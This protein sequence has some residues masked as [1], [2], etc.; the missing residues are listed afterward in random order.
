M[1][2]SSIRWWLLVTLV[3]VWAPGRSAELTPTCAGLSGGPRQLAL[4]LLESEHP[5]DCCD[6][7]I[8]RCLEAEQVC[9]LTWRLAENICRRADQ[10]QDRARIHRA[11]SRRA[12]SMLAGEPP[13]TINLEDTPSVGRADAPVEVVV[14]ACAR[15][16]FCAK[17][18]LELERS[19]SSG[20]LAGQARLYLKV[21]PIRGH[22][23]SKEAGLAFVAAAR[24]GRFWEFLDHAY[25]NFDSFSVAELPTW[26]A[27]VGMDREIFGDHLADPATRE[28][29]VASKKEGLRNDVEVT[30]TVFI[31]QRR[32]V[33]DL[34]TV[35]LVDIIGEEA[36]RRAGEIYRP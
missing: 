16:P 26:A 6:D 2:K 12:R 20:A 34:T 29:L 15:C 28:L 4:E 10:G 7:T 3:L 13:V 30:P 22:R 19:I 5:Y 14:Y 24:Q 27:A 36:D 32:W 21:F 25:A 23:F 18:V 17:L 35:E 33:G 31:N 1:K 11:L 8:A 9:R